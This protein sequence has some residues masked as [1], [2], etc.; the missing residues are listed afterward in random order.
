MSTAV[1]SNLRLGN[2][3]V[4]RSG[5]RTSREVPVDL[6]TKV[7]LSSL[8]AIFGYAVFQF[9]GVVSEY[10]SVCLLA[11]GVLALVYWL[12]AW[13]ADPAPPL[14]RELWWLLVLLLLAARNPPPDEED[15]GAVAC[16][17]VEDVIISR[18]TN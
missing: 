9:G 14:D 7:Y 13:R 11:L 15:T 8:G 18:K 5:D 2:K 6:L 17:V 4:R 10:W 3:P 16:V 1:P 12:R